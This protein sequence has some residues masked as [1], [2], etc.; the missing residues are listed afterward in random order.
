MKHKS[1]A[2]RLAI[3]RAAFAVVT[4]RG[5][6]DTKVEDV[7]QRAGVAKGTV[8][9]YFRDKPAIYIGLVD[10]LL[11]QALAVMAG[12]RAEQISPRAKL[13]RMF[14][15]WAAGVFAKP[16]VTALL[17]LENV[18]QSNAVM[19]RFK[20]HVLPHIHELTGAVAEVVSEGIACGEFRPV[21]PQLAAMMY[22]GAFRAGMHGATV[23][24]SGPDSVKS[25]EELFFRGLL[26]PKRRTTQSRT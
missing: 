12:I 15:V 18:N 19:R 17:S 10:W 24:S 26:A 1:E 25:V 11:E 14:E 2:K 16:A 23:G 21:D 3:V 20:R 6:S 4:E 13:Q 22:M 5:Y 9:L 7:A 8:Y